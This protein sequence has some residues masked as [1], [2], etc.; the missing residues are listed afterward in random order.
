[1]HRCGASIL[2]AVTALPFLLISAY[3]YILMDIP[4]LLRLWQPSFDSNRIEWNGSAIPL[5]RSFY[6][7][8]P[9][10]WYWRGLTVTFAPATLGIDPLGWW[11][12]FQFLVQLMPL[13]A[14]W[15]LEARR[16][17]NQSTPQSL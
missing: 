16:A 11:A 5:L 9:L 4:K 15:M 12:G 17:L 1:M 8:G 2:R 3:C 13:Y 7:I 10:D 6:H 14:I